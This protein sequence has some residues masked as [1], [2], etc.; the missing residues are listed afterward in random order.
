MSSWKRFEDIEAWGKARTLAKEIS[1]ILNR[2]ALKHEYELKSQMKRSSG[3]VMDNIAEGFERGGN[4]EF[5]QFLS[6]S[7]E[8]N[9]EIRSQLYRLFDNNFISKKQFDN[10]YK[11]SENISKMITGLIKYLR[12][13][14]TKGYKFK[15]DRGNYISTTNPE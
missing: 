15:E 1:D 13:Q 12:D 14:K 9:A 7:K 11:E 8:S 2:D 5:I 6:F 3:S 4:R 10:L